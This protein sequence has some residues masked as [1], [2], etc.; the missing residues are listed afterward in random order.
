MNEFSICVFDSRDARVK[1]LRAE[2][3]PSRLV[4]VVQANGREV[5]AK[6]KADALWL[7]P[8]QA[9]AWYRLDPKRLFE[10]EVVATPVEEQSKG[11]PPFLMIGIYLPPG[12]RYTVRKELEFVARALVAAVGKL[13]HLSKQL[14]PMIATMPENLL[15]DKIFPG[16]VVAVIEKTAGESPTRPVS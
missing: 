6:V 3:G 9:M 16:D 11:F 12:H 13:Q 15:M 14:V 7:T 10:A 1:E 4:Q 2:I 5:R 8:T